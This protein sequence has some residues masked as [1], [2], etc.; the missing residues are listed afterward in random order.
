[1]SRRAAGVSSPEPGNALGR[2][3]TT[4]DQIQRPAHIYIV[5]GAV[6][7]DQDF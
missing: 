2:W 4:H 1:L 6:E 5:I 3:S 7:F